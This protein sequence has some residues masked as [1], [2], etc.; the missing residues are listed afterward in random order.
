ME[1]LYILAVFNGTYKQVHHIGAF[2]EVKITYDAMLRGA[3]TAGL[4]TDSLIFISL[5]FLPYEIKR[6]KL[7]DSQV[8][9]L[10]ES[11]RKHKVNLNNTTN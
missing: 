10:K 6:L 8:E 1:P 4:D 11:F 2:N 5:D 3:R 9:W 7:E